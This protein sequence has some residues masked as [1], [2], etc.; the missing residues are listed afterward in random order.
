MMLFGKAAARRLWN[1]AVVRKHAAFDATRHGPR[2]PGRAS[3]V[4]AAAVVLLTLGLALSTRPVQAQPSQAAP[5][6]SQPTARAS[7]A[8]V[9][10]E[11][12]RAVRAGQFGLAAELLDKAT[13]R[14]ADPQLQ[15]MAEWVSAYNTDHS[16]LLGERRQQFEKTLADMT[17]LI[18][19]GK[20][21][22]AIDYATRAYVLAEDKPGFSKLPAVRGLIDRITALA[23]DAEARQQW[24]K[25]A[26]L[27]ADLAQVD[28]DRQLWRDKLRGAARANRILQF[29]APDRLRD[30]MA[31]DAKNVADNLSVLREEEPRPEAADAAAE[32]TTRPIDIR[33]QLDWREELRGIKPDMFWAALIDVRANY[34]RDVDFVQLVATGLNGVRALLTTA[35]LETAFPGLADA[36]RKRQ[37]AATL[38]DLEAQL[39]RATQGTEVLTAA[40]V[41]RRL[42]E[43]TRSTVR[44]PDE[45]VVYEFSDAALASLDAYTSML[46]P[47][48]W[49][50]FN[51]RTQGEFS[52]VGIQ[53]QNDEDGSLKVVTP[54]EDSPAFRSGIKAGDIITHVDGK[55]MKGVTT[56]QAVR[57]ITGPVGTPVTLTIRSSDGSVRDHRLIRDTIRVASLK[58]FVHRPGGRWDYFI[59]PEQ[60]IAY[61]RL[62]DFTRTSSD[63]L[64]RVAVELKAAGARGLI[65]DLRGN[66]GGLLT[67]AIEVANKFL[68]GGVI[69]STRAQRPTPQQQTTATARPDADEITLPLVVLV[70]QQSASASEIVAGALKDHGRALVVGERTYGKGS[71]QMPFDVGQR[72]AYLKLTISHYYLPSG[73]SLHR[74]EDSKDWGVEPD[75]VV[76]MTPEQMVTAQLGRM[77]FDVIRQS[78]EEAPPPTTRPNRPVIRTPQELIRRD[79]QLGAALLLMRLQLNQSELAAAEPSRTGG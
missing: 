54:I 69:V 39:R 34:W 78:D 37:L 77:Q 74:D 65:L 44:L 2:R 25:A 58:G 23:A 71:V 72:N 7:S 31:E 53:I 64:D 33:L 27:Y 55:P 24:V 66:P 76:E 36:A 79:S 18:E 28:P 5:G 8:D 38:D 68:A 59:D 15:R 17:R 10:V 3:A 56:T 35:G 19:A 43:A 63:E 9:R 16:V 41:Y 61:L 73:R 60:R 48:Q 75:V 49:E 47:A 57:I 70:N 50:E 67:A 12:F 45:V 52:G 6:V 32:P 46:W 22:A 14:T 1:L 20:D 30:L 4:I 11:A 26:R 13:A 42:F 51:K 29:Y 21:E 62:T 40:Q